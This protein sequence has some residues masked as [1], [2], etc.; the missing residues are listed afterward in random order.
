MS[1]G[2]ESFDINSR[3]YVY[4]PADSDIAGLTVDGTQYSTVETAILDTINNHLEDN[5]MENL[6][7]LGD[8]KLRVDVDLGNSDIIFTM[9]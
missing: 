5:T 9:I 1:S 2:T 3:T 4:T 8:V 6:Y 7:L